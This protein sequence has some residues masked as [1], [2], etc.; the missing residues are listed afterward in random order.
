MTI[1]DTL[2]L[3]TCGAIMLLPIAFL[4]IATF[5]GIFFDIDITDPRFWNNDDH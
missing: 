2:M 1:F 3:S 5:L 4:F